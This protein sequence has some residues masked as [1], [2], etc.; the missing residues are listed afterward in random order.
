MD[1][2]LNIVSLPEQFS[3]FA[4]SQFEVNTNKGDTEVESSLTYYNLQA[5]VKSYILYTLVN[6][7]SS[8]EYLAYTN[9]WKVNY[10]MT[11][12]PVA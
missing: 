5:L 2:Q 11:M 10:V 12:S 8:K 7:D 4:M 1:V 3:E 9:K 6:T